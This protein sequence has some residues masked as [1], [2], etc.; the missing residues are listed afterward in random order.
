MIKI[1]LIK[2]TSG[3]EKGWYMYISTVLSGK[4]GDKAWLVSERYKPGDSPTGEY[5]L[6][7]YYHM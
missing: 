5:C 2:A 6:N 1:I 7:F 3:T 4:T